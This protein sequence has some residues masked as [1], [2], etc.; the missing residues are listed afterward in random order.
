MSKPQLY[1]DLL[2]N[3]IIQI[4]E[5]SGSGEI[6]YTLNFNKIIG[7]PELFDAYSLIAENFIKTKNIEFDKICALNIDSIPYATN[8]STSFSKGILYVTDNGNDHND[9]GNI[10]NIKIE[11]GMNIDDRI[12]LIITSTTPDYFINNVITKINKFGGKFVGLV[13]LWDF[14]E[15][16][17]LPVLVDKHPVL[18]IINLYDLCNNLENNN[19]LN[20]YATEHVKFYCEKLMK[21][22]IR[23]YSPPVIS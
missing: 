12:L 13:V 9:K 20:N 5:L 23:Q 6:P 1:K 19:M 22:R 15:G 17:Y 7:N 18:S 2:D 16:E 3:N 8:I 14:N 10:K 4:K 11:G 21:Q